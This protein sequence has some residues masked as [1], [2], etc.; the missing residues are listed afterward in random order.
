MKTKL[1][2]SPCPLSKGFSL[3]KMFLY[4]Q[5]HINANILVP[6][7]AVSKHLQLGNWKAWSTV[8]C[9]VLIHGKF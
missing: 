2:I 9:D 1:C 7:Q 4:F 8:L 3:E 5:K 6:G